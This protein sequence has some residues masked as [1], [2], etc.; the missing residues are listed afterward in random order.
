MLDYITWKPSA[1]IYIQIRHI[2]PFDHSM[3]RKTHLLGLCTTQLESQSCGVFFGLLHLKA[4]GSQPKHDLLH[5]HVQ[6]SGEKLK[7]KVGER[8]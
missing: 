3:A 2:V 5:L 8:R 1:L 4:Q 6:G 7:E